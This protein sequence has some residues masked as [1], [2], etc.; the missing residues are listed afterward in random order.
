MAYTFQKNILAPLNIN[1][2]RGTN[3]DNQ[4]IQLLKKGFL[5]ESC[6]WV[7]LER[8]AHIFS[9]DNNSI[10]IFPI[11]WYLTVLGLHA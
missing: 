5:L 9:H 1:L 4:L 2:L 6:L 8:Y 10:N 11:G 3:P 7:Q